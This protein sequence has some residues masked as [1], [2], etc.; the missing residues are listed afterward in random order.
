MGAAE[1]LSDH[2]VVN[3]FSGTRHVHRVGE[4]SPFRLLASRRVLG[5][6][7]QDLVR[8]KAYGAW[9]VLLLGGTASWVYQHD[10]VLVHVWRVERTR[11]ELVVGAVDRVAAL[12]SDHISIIG[13]HLASLRRSSTRKIAYRHVKAL[14]GAPDVTRAALHGD[15]AHAGV[16]DGGSPIAI[17]ALKWFIRYPFGG[18]SH[19]R[20]VGALVGKQELAADH[21]LVVACVHDHRQAEYKP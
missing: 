13:Q 12:E 10:C 14:D 15:H 3:R 1:V 11:E 9:N 20:H 5:L 6:V 21:D 4:V 19:Q 18:H 8:L 16:L 7:L 17:E 2:H